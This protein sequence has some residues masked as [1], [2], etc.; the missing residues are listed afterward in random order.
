[1]GCFEPCST[2]AFEGVPL[3]KVK[4][5]VVRR[6]RGGGDRIRAL[7]VLSAV[8]VAIAVEQLA[9]CR[10]AAV[11]LDHHKVSV[12]VVGAHGD[13]IDAIVSS[14]AA[15]RGEYRRA[16][17]GPLLPGTNADSHETERDRNDPQAAEFPHFR[18]FTL[19][20]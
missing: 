3:H 1:M 13:H 7:R 11:V 14:G 5:H 12:V 15:G 6:G 8:V 2:S 4:K 19:Q 9:E 20:V 17:G 18:T 10:P 16:P